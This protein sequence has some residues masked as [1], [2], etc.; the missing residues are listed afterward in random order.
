MRFSSAGSLLMGLK[1][2]TDCLIIHP[3]AA[4]RGRKADLWR[5]PA[6]LASLGLFPMQMA[7]RV[8]LSSPRAHRGE[9]S[10]KP[11]IARFAGNGALP[12]PRPCCAQHAS[13]AR[14]MELNL[15][16]HIAGLRK[17]RSCAFHCNATAKE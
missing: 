15:G 3:E 9:R 16:V 2:Q 10:P 17:E 6:G 5:L 11:E 14:E 12:R 1:Q 4:W 8:W 7:A 13:F